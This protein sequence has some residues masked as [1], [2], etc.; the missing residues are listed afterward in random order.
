MQKIYSLFELKSVNED[1]RILTGI[2]TNNS[3]DRA[4]DV[5]ETRGLRW[6]LPIAFLLSHDSNA[7]IG[8]VIEARAT[9][10][11]LEIKAQIAKIDEPGP[12]RSRL[13]ESW[14]GIKA[15]LWAGLSIGFKALK[16]ERIETGLRFL[17]AEILEISAVAVPA[18]PGAS[19]THVR[20][21]REIDQAWRRA[22]SVY[23]LKLGR[24]VYR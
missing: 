23:S 4:G 13:S 12:L 19:I 8:K 18:C 24:T 17:E 16:T 6:N 2:A 3:L 7:P 21:I 15:G 10:A 9:N 20:Q 22:H 11:G 5:V 1:S 14:A